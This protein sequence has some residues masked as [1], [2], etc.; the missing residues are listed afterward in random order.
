MTYGK[1]KRLS[2]GKKGVKKKAVDSFS[3]KEWYDIKAPS[4]FTDRNVG[5][6]LATRSQGTKLA[7]DSLNGRILNA[8]LADL[9]KNEDQAFRVIRLK[10]E[11]VQGKNVL[12]NF[13]GMDFTTDKLRS[14]IKK[15]QRIIETHVNVKTLDGYHLRMFAIAF[16]DVKS[17]IRKTAY[18]KGS[19]MKQ[20]RKKMA[21]IMIR[22]ASTVELKDL[23]LKFIPDS[24]ATEIKK[25]CGGIYPLKEIHIRKVKIIKAPR[26]DAS[27]LMELHPDEEETETGI[28]VEQPAAVVAEVV[29]A[30]PAPEVAAAQ[31]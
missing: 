19:Q 6:T 25:R 26:Y 16:T 27:K 4:Y 20:V 14:L 18:A 10:V 28:K 2:K 9:N 15:W 30:A 23:V 1:N 8:S 31:N 3:K 29:A 21:E 5:K 13:Y 22:E 17:P 7:S 24:I 12:T 11:E